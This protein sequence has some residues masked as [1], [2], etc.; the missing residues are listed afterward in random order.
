M[1]SDLTVLYD[2]SASTQKEDHEFVVLF[3]HSTCVIDIVPPGTKVLQQDVLRGFEHQVFVM[4]AIVRIH[5]IISPVRER[6]GERIYVKYF[7][8]SFTHGPGSIGIV[9]LHA[10]K[11]RKRFL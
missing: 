8:T 2:F 7:D 10:L 1:S 5:T 9:E 11:E 4:H 3:S 6:R